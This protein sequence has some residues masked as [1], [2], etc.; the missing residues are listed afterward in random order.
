VTVVDY[1]TCTASAWEGDPGR[2]RACNG[3]LTG[4]QRAWCSEECS[5]WFGR[6]HWWTWAS[7]AAKRRDGNQCVVC[8]R[9]P[10]EVRDEKI[11]EGWDR[12]DATKF[13]ILETDHI[14]PVLG[15]HAE[16]GCHHH[17]DG[18]RTLCAY[19]HLERHHGERHKQLSLE[20]A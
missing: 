20:A 13:T 10:I 15:R 16:T 3:E 12:R 4:R 9:D 8:R 11:A 1:L 18:L 17:L 6:H 7:R 19:H 2:C 14:E 5:R